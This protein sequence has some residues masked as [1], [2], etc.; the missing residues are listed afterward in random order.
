[1]FLGEQFVRRTLLI[2]SM[3]SGRKLKLLERR[4]VTFLLILYCSRL[5]LS[6]RLQRR[7][8]GKLLNEM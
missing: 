7:G 6:S 4:D 5:E 2:E 3:L 1:M 8:S